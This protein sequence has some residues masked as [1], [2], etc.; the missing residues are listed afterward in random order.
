MSSNQSSDIINPR[1]AELECWERLLKGSDFKQTIEVYVT[2]R[3]AILNREISILAQSPSQD[4][5]IKI[6]A[7][8]NRIDEITAIIKRADFKQHEIMQFKKENN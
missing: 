2:G 5:A 4:N 6:T 8:H 7:L 3:I 1:I